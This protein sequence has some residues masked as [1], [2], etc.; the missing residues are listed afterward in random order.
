MGCKSPPVK[1]RNLWATVPDSNQPTFQQERECTEGY[2]ARAGNPTGEQAGGAPEAADPSKPPKIATVSVVSKCDMSVNQKMKATQD[3]PSL[4]WNFLNTDNSPATIP[5][6]TFDISGTI[7]GVVTTAGTYSF[8]VILS[9]GGSEVDSKPFK[10]VVAPCKPGMDIK[11]SHPLPGAIITSK[12]MPKRVHPVTGQLRPHKGIDL[13]YPGG[14]VGDVLASADGE[15]VFAGVQNG[16]GNIVI[17]GHSNAAGKRMCVTKYAHLDRIYVTVGMKVA[18]GDKVGLEGNTGVGT[19]KH[20][21]FEIRSGSGQGDQV[22]D[23]EIYLSGAVMSA[24]SAPPVDP[25]TGDSDPG[26]APTTP[27]DVEVNDNGTVKLTPD[28]VN[29]AC[30]GYVTDTSTTEN[31]GADPSGGASSSNTPATS[32]KQY[33]SKCKPD[34]YTPPTQSEVVSRIK[35]V[36]DADGSLDDEDKKFILFVARIESRYDPYAKNPTSSATGLFQFLDALAMK[37]FP[38]IGE[39]PTCENRTNIE[40]AT[41]AMIKFYKQELLAYWNSYVASGKTKIAGKPI[42][43]TA[44]SARY[45][46]LSK[47]VMIYSCFH[48]DGAG[49]AQKGID[50]QGVE[51]CLRKLNDGN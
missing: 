20:L 24:K 50:K 3:K 34:P 17:L 35:A 22:F 18:A 36:M 47:T 19:G 48:H 8:T 15:V 23:P 5:G 11:F 38:M 10:L 42:V 21:H 28:K 29:S 37:Y 9:D 32:P 4:S 7:S 39:K 1:I 2:L 30:S 40:K 41:K 14:R 51:Y 49:N 27:S 25:T 33:S 43:L 6:L 46:G 44:H 31:S 16:Y 13:A 12:C 45:P 26:K